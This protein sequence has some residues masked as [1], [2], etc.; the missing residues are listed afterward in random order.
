M[1]ATRN[2]RQRAAAVNGIR[3]AIRALMVCA[4]LLGVVLVVSACQTIAP[5]G[6]LPA[7]GSSD[8]ATTVSRADAEAAAALRQVIEAEPAVL[9]PQTAFARAFYER[10]QFRPAWT[11]PIG[12]DE[13]GRQV[14]AVLETAWADGLGSVAVPVAAESGEGPLDAVTRARRDASLTAA[15]ADYVHSA[16]PLRPVWAPPIA[17]GVLGALEA[18]AAD[19]P[20]ATRPGRLFRL[21]SED[22]RHAR[23]RRGLLRYHALADAGGWPLIEADG[24]KLEPGDRHGDILVVR[25]RL[26]ATG[27]L[28][29]GPVPA[30]PERI[31][32]DL[33]AAIERFQARHGLTVDGILGPRT[34]AALAVSA[35]DRVRQMALNLRRLSQMPPP[36]GGRSV[37]VNIAGAVLEGREDGVTIFRTDVI[38]GMED[39]PT[40]RL[41]SAI[42]TLVLNP[43]WTVPTSIASE[44]LLPKLR[45]DP[46]YLTRN[47]FQVFDGWT[48]ESEELDPATIDWHSEDLDIRG[49]RLRQRPGASNALG[50]IKFM[51][52]NDHDVY[53]HSTPSRGL[54]A[55][56]ERTFSSGCV[57]VR[58]P[59][60]LATFVM[61]EPEA[62]NPETFKGRMASGQTRSVHPGQS[63]P[64]AL[65][66][67]TAWVDE[68]GTVQFR[69]DVYGHDA[70]DMA[71][72]ARSM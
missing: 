14:Q 22:D 11:T 69:R 71:M 64:V 25:A 19:D 34:R 24:P 54:F 6:P 10:R 50:A 41:R 55:R 37:E 49:L 35:E 40:P 16:L 36:P 17:E 70:R 29:G 15:L 61:N 31:D 2:G 43:T 30:D 27:D 18:I 48:R 13:R 38:V 58:D 51:F 59:I 9:A 53:L 23:L 44:D 47:S 42:N 66:Y 45:D 33:A 56:S 52:P 68:A 72:M 62:W 3:A 1:T 20:S 5:G 7:T 4:G 32:P 46:E 57:R 28:S 65:V 12:L 21:V 67:F 63:V 60:D 39:R 8:A 26:R